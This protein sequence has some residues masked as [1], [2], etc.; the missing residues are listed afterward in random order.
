MESSDAFRGAEK[1]RQWLEARTRHDKATALWRACRQHTDMTGD[2]SS[3]R[4]RL[5]LI[6]TVGSL[7]ARSLRRGLLLAPCIP[8]FHISCPIAYMTRIPILTVLVLCICLHIIRTLDILTPISVSHL[9]YASS[10]VSQNCP[11]KV[12]TMAQRNVSP[13]LAMPL[14]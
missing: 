13:R 3:T 5:A 8:Y 12:S 11:S 4:N 9:F 10:A 2:P 7:A 1:P 14:L 6:S